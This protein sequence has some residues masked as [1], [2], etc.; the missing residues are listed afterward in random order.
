MIQLTIKELLDS[1][2]YEPEYQ[3]ALFQMLEKFVKEYQDMS[4]MTAINQAKELFETF[5]NG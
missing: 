2:V 3:I 5:K 4:D 1:D